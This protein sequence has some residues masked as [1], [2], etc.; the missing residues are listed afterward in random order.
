MK[1]NIWEDYEFM[2]L[3]DVLAFI[4]DNRGKTVPTDENGNHMLI[5]TNCVRNRRYIG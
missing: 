5:E 3:P 4:V 1:F 2:D